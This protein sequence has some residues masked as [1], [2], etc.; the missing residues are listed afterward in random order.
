[1]KKILNDWYLIL[2]MCATIGLAP[3]V[4][5][6]HLFGKIQWVL[7]GAIGMALVDWGDLLFHGFPF[8]LLIRLIITRFFKR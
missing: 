4:P 3:F 7:G 5:A 1:M 6:P 2:F 8:L